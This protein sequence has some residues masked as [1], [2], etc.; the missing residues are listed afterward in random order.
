MLLML[1]RFLCC[2]SSIRIIMRDRNGDPCTAMRKTRSELRLW[3]SYG[4]LRAHAGLQRHQ[5]S[6]LQDHKLS[7]GY[8]IGRPQSK[9][10]ITPPNG[11]THPTRAIVPEQQEQQ[12][13]VA[14]LVAAALRIDQLFNF[15]A[16]EVLPVA[17]AIR[18]RPV[19]RLFPS[20]HHFVES[21][22]SSRPPN[23]HKQGRGLCSIYNKDSFC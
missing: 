14:G 23:P 22:P 13:T 17:V 4:Y 16:G 10:T 3:S 21:F 18:R 19:F 6:F 7:T 11:A 8:R 9:L 12:A 5:R 20:G 2:R 15:A 1:V